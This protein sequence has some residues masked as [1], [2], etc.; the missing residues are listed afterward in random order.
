GAH[1]LRDPL[2]RL[3]PVERRSV[4]HTDAARELLEIASGIAVANDVEVADRRLLR[5]GSQEDVNPLELRQPPGKADTAVTRRRRGL[6]TVW[7]DR[8]AGSAPD[9]ADRCTIVTSAPAPCNSA[10][11]SSR[12]VSAPPT[13]RACGATMTMAGQL[14]APSAPRRH[15]G[16]ARA[17]RPPR[18]MR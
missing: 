15:A 10:Q 6:A 9:P 4:I 11:T 16:R 12:C 8:T 1:Q 18:P 14:I 7:R 13:R 2:A 3:P 5:D 17:P